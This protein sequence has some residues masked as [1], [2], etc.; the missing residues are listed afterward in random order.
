MTGR[1]AIVGI[2]MLCAL[3]ISAVAAQ[4]AMAVSGTTAFTCLDGKGVLRGEHCLTTGTKPA[5]FGHVAFAENTTTE[6][7]L[8][9]AETQNETKEASTQI[10]KETIAG[11][12]L[13]LKATGVTGTGTLTNKKME[14]GEHYVEGTATIKYTG[15]T[16]AAPAGKGCKVFTDTNKIKGAEGQIDAHLEYTTTQQGDS[17]KFTP[18]TGNTGAG[19]P[20]AAF[21]I[22]GCSPAVPAIEGTWEITGSA[23]C[24][25]DGATIKCDHTEITTQ[26]TL[27]G[28]GAKAGFEGAI[29]VKGRANSSEAYKPLSMTTVV[30]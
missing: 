2:C 5:T 21:F 7:E 4:S 10:L 20:F 14:D 30:T 13:E 19:V 23:T 15:V 16:V 6:T 27:K 26:N 29:T 25:I 3:I 11:V 22:E 9:N 1:R 17:I 12:P 8:T 18:A 28:K 24:K